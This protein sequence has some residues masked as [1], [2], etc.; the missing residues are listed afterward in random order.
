MTAT[1]AFASA[2]ARALGRRS[3][4]HSIT[5]SVLSSGSARY[6]TSGRSSSTLNR[7]TS[8]AT[9][10]RVSVRNGGVCAASTTA[11]IEASS[12]SCS[13]TM[14]ERSPSPTR[15]CTSADTAARRIDSS[16]PTRK[17]TAMAAVILAARRTARTGRPAPPRPPAQSRRPPRRPRPT[18]AVARWPRR[19]A[20]T[21]STHR[22]PT[23]TGSMTMPRSGDT[24]PATSAAGSPYSITKP[25]T[26]TASRLARVPTSGS[27]PNTSRLGSATPSWAPSVTPSGTASGPRACSRRASGGPRTV[28][29]AVAPTDN[30]KPT[31][32]TS[33]GSTSSRPITAT[34]SRRGGSRSRPRANPT[35]LNPAIAPARSTDGSARVS[36]TNQPISASVAANRTPVRARRSNGPAAANTNATFWPDTAVRCDRPLRRKRSIMSGGW[37][38]SSPMIRPRARAA[39]ADGI[40]DEPR[41][42]RSRTR[43]D[44]TASGRPSRRSP[45]TSYRNAPTTCSHDT[46]AARAGRS[47]WRAPETHTRSPCCQRATAACVAGPRT[48]TSKRSPSTWSSSRVEPWDEAGSDATVTHPLNA[49]SRSGASEAT[50]STE[51]TVATPASSARPTANVHRRTS[52]TAP[53]TATPASTGDRRHTATA[54]TTAASPTT[55]GSPRPSHRIRTAEVDGT[56]RRPPPRLLRRAHRHPT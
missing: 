19:P 47:G 22:T 34:A 31:E 35:A 4:P 15:V 25:A 40:D 6:S 8:R 24:A 43:F 17:C 13:S 37:S 11:A 42:M 10:T 14:S 49:P 51:R 18:A 55:A 38:R 32:R 52:A 3:L 33:S 36:T 41:S 20:A 46:R 7:P 16:S 54:T 48:H 12:W 28:T 2:S 21:R 29:P 56:R 50:E 1:P 23:S 5:S 45:R 26:G 27:R 53:R 9:T 39:S 30:Q 44:A